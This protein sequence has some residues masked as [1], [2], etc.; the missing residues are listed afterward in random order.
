[1]RSYYFYYWLGERLALLLPKKAAYSLSGLISGFYSRFLHADLAVIKVNFK[2]VLPQGVLER[3]G[4][5][6]A[7]ELIRN[8]GF[9]LVDL[10]Y[11][12]ELSSDFVKRHV[13]IQGLSH[14]EEALGKKRGAILASAHVGNWEMG[15]MV[16]SR[17][18]Y[19]VYTVAVPH[20]DLRIDGIFERRRETNGVTALRLGD[21][22]KEL[23]RVLERN[24][25]VALNGDRLYQGEGIRVSFLRRMVEMPR[26]LA[27]L[28]TVTGAAVLPT[29]FLMKQRNEYLLEI[30]SP[31]EF[32]EEAQCVQQFARRLEDVVRRYPTQWFI[33]QPFWEAP[34]WPS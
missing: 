26:G 19:P 16:V 7:R 17:L 27:R 13:E 30:Q 14:L 6:G 34:E 11:A 1:M 4:E 31:L 9:Y 12:R 20:Q 33:F 28:G 8:F 5:S 24:G 21:S 32:Q 2:E 29:F 10:F 3:E 15:G 18:G 23:Y 25:V 22:I